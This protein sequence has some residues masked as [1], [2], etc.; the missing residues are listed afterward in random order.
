MVVTFLFVLLSGRFSEFC[1]WILCRLVACH[2]DNTWISEA[3]RVNKILNTHLDHFESIID[4]ESF[5]NFKQKLTNVK[6]PA[7]YSKKMNIDACVYILSALNIASGLED[8]KVKFR[9]CEL[10]GFP[11]TEEQQKKEVQG[12][13]AKEMTTWNSKVTK[14]ASLLNPEFGDFLD[15]CDTLWT[16]VEREQRRRDNDGRGK[17]EKLGYVSCGVD[18]A[19]LFTS[20]TTLSPGLRI[21]LLEAQVKPELRT[22]YYHPPLFSE[23]ETRQWLHLWA[24]WE[25]VYSMAVALLGKVLDE[26]LPFAPVER[27]AKSKT[28]TESGSESLLAASIKSDFNDYIHKVREKYFRGVWDKAEV[29]V[30][31]RRAKRLLYRFI[32]NQ[33]SVDPNYFWAYP[34]CLQGW[35]S[36]VVEG[37]KTTYGPYSM[38]PTEGM[39]AARE[40]DQ[41]EVLHCPWYLETHKWSL[42]FNGLEKSSLQIIQKGGAPLPVLSESKF[43][44]TLE[45]AS[46]LV[47]VER[48][49]ENVVVAVDR[50]RKGK[51]GARKEETKAESKKVESI[52][53]ESRRGDSKKTTSR[54]TGGPSGEISLF[55]SS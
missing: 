44:D 41:W 12:M 8:L 1:F 4:A 11:L 36:V 43:A 20:V 46:Y 50:S 15:A 47:N 6:N 33:E 32:V 23:A 25:Q 51:L 26:I 3:R 9:N 39:D 17:K 18:R 7:W 40:M 38:Y 42:P 19:R 5:K 10:E 28:A 49:L 48:E 37:E 53:K 29:P 24:M 54:D 55:N 22:L 31:R 2:V 45:E 30:L 14:F 16:F 21:Q 13:M 52:R 34:M 35:N 27:I